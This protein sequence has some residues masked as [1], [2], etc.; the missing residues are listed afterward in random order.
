MCFVPCL[1]ALATDLSRV[2]SARSGQRVQVPLLLRKNVG[3]FDSLSLLFVELS[4]NRL[5]EPQGLAG[6]R[7]QRPPRYGQNN[8]EYGSMGVSVEDAYK[9]CTTICGISNS[10]IAKRKGKTRLTRSTLRSRTICV[11]RLWWRGGCSGGGWWGGVSEAMTET[12]RRA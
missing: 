11:N 8:F 4:S 6:K 5:A 9:S 10:D 3:S 7:N 2:S 12:A 1:P